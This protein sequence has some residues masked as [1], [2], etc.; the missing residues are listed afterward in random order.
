MG[1]LQR[2]FGNGLQGLLDLFIFLFCM[3]LSLSVHELCHGYTAYK[4][5]DHTAK[6]HGRLTLNPFHHLDL[7]GTLMMIFYGFGWAKPVPVNTANFTRKIS[8][9]TGMALTA[10]AGPIS[11][12]ILSF[13]AF[14]LIALILK[15]PITP[16]LAL[17]L[18]ILGRLCVLN[19]SLGLF[20]LIPFPPLDGSRILMALLPNRIYWKVA[21]L[22]RY[23]FILLILLINI[24]AVLGGLSTIVIWLLTMYANIFG[25]PANLLL[26]LLFSMM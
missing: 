24:P 13:V 15:F 21:Q 22:E 14:S 9:K 4:L 16:I 1:N 7:F 3:F 25:I 6:A 11:N 19:V 8:Q 17:C 2:Y 10:I 5:G 12:F 20:N 26:N 18:A 23:S